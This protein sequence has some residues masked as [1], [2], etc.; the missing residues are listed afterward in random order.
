MKKTLEQIQTL[1]E[2]NQQVTQ[3]R[4]ELEIQSARVR[5]HERLL[6]EK[7]RRAEQVHKE[8]IEAAKEADAKQL[9]IDEAE[10]EI[11]RFRVQL[12]V[13]K[14]QK[15]Y[16]AIQHSIS[17]NTADIQKWEDEELTALQAIDELSEEEQRLAREIRQAELDLQS[18]KDDVATKTDDR[19][20]HLR[21]LEEQGQ[22][23]RQQIS[24][25][26]LSAYDRLTPSR[27]TKALAVVKDHIC[28]GCFTRVTKQTEN[29]LMRGEEI[30]YC[31]SC[32]RMLR[33][34]E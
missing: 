3:V 7:R 4:R 6:Q 34:P 18:L 13:T 10:Q 25:S 24:P 8:R 26:V 22:Q 21:E 17:S 30:V 1:Q 29:L 23:L 5:T 15:E 28:Q 32:G 9:Q 12:N 27:R 20:Q 14:H 31:H 11:A 2:L 33:R 16:D 19:N